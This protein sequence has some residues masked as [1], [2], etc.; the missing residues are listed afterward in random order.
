MVVI[1]RN[2]LSLLALSSFVLANVGAWMHF[3]LGCGAGGGHGACSAVADLADPGCPWSGCCKVSTGQET[4]AHAVPEAQAA[5]HFSTLT[6]PRHARDVCVICQF[7]LVAK[8][9]G[10]DA[11]PGLTVGTVPARVV[12]DVTTETVASCTRRPD[13]RAPPLA[14]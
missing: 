14:V 7:L 6:T 2:Y 10:N 1:R 5:G 9:L 4:A 3:G 12:L 8:S 11:E 13:C